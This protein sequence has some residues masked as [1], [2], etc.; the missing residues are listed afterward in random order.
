MYAVATAGI[1]AVRSPRAIKSWLNHSSVV[2]LPE[3]SN[4]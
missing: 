2:H 1:S 4:V 3:A